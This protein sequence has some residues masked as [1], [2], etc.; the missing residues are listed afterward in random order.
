[1][2][3]NFFK[4]KMG[5]IKR[6][7]WKKRKLFRFCSIFYRKSRTIDRNIWKIN[8]IQLFIFFF[9]YFDEKKHE[10]TFKPKIWPISTKN[11]IF[12]E[13]SENQ[14]KIIFQKS[15]LEATPT[16]NLIFRCFKKK[17]DFS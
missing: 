13:I 9:V 16:G 1:M 12:I 8:K 10:K 11:P 3:N 15:S 14:T 6:N 2:K 7:F 5:Q 4:R 17:I